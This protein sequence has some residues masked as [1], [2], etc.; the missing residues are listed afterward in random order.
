MDEKEDDKNATENDEKEIDLK[1]DT[2]NDEEL[3]NEGEIKEEI[4][5]KSDFEEEEKIIYSNSTSEFLV[6][7]A[8]E[9]DDDLEQ[10]QLKKK[11]KMIKL[12]YSD[13]EEE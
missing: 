1:N 10:I 4:E 2:E 12:F 3:K 9:E 7:F 13:E 8:F 6:Q 11:N 5:H